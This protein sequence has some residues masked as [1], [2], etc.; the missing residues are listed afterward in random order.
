MNNMGTPENRGEPKGSQKKHKT[1][2]ITK[3]ITT[4][5][6]LLI[7]ADFTVKTNTDSTT[8]TTLILLL[9]TVGDLQRHRQHW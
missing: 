4:S 3:T 5:D 1:K 7:A 2:Q 9:K 6:K 8:C